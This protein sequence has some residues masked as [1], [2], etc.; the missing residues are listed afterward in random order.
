MFKNDI[1]VFNI[2]ADDYIPQ[3]QLF[4][5]NFKKNHP[6]IDIYCITLEN[7]KF[8]SNLFETIPINKI[9]SIKNLEFLKFKYNILEFST[10]VKPYIF[11]YLF[12]KYSYKKILYF[13]SDIVVYK[14][15]NKLILKLDNFEAVITP[16]IRK[17]INDDKQPGEIDFSKSGYY[18]AGFLG[19]KKNINTLK[20]LQ[21]W[22]KKVE[23]Y[24]Y[25]DFNKFYFVDQRWLDY[26]PIFLNT[27]IIK[28]PGYNVAYFNLQEYVGKIDPKKIFFIHFSGY[29]K[30]RVSVYQNRFNFKLLNKY[31]S[32]FKEYDIEINKLKKKQKHSYK[33]DYFD[34]HV[35]ISSEVKKI[36]L[37]NEIV[38]QNKLNVKKPF[39]TKVKNNI[40]SYLN[41]ESQ[42]VPVTNLSRLIYA[43]SPLLQQKFPH[44]DFDRLSHHSLFEYISWF[45]DESG[46]DLSIDKS[47]IESQKKILEKIGIILKLYNSFKIKNKLLRFF[48][49]FKYFFQIMKI[50]DKKLYIKNI[51]LF[52]LGR[53]VD[54]KTLKNSLK[55][56]AKIN[57]YKKVL[58]INIIE[59]EEFKK[60]VN[61]GKEKKYD[62]VQKII[63]LTYKVFGLSVLNLASI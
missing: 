60:V 10:A 36:F 25:I 17:M 35:F 33:Y 26:A 24:C 7:T 34:N 27:Y 43:N 14:P 51:Y 39:S 28:E 4:S 40:Y 1:C 18:N 5:E 38:K 37:N 55:S 48:L 41:N 56:K 54:Q 15:I 50:K 49:R 6:N 61:L 29:D 52:L 2:I 23:Q 44:A 19:L 21:W 45:I 47:F 22:M 31:S 8:R 53:N 32:Y 46:K 30:D 58:F 12:E 11:K 3:Q 57:N 59:S 20:F 16:H 9:S 13:D 63:K 62:I 42:F